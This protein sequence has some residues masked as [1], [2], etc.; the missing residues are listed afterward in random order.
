MVQN[1][2]KRRQHLRNLTASSIKISIFFSAAKFNVL[3]G[4]SQRVFIE[5]ISLP[6]QIPGIFDYT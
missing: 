1:N 4:Y 5:K 6:G 3:F 2:A